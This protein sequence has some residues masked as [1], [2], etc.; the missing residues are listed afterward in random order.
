MDSESKRKDFIER[1]K[2]MC[3]QAGPQMPQIVYNKCTDLGYWI[4]DYDNHQDDVESRKNLEEMIGEVWI[5][6]MC[7]MQYYDIDFDHMEGHM[8]DQI[9]R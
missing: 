3:E 6:L 7:L 2:Q 5:G 9:G 8:N 4:R 1:C